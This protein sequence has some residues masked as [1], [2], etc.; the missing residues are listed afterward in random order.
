MRHAQLVTLCFV[1]GSWLGAPALAHACSCAGPLPS[2]ARNA[3]ASDTVFV[4]SVAA[5]QAPDPRL[6]VN[7]AP[8]SPGSRVVVES[9]LS[10]ADGPMRIVFDVRQLYKGPDAGQIVLIADRICDPPFNV[11]QE[12]LVYASER[13][14]RIETSVCSR[15]RLTRE[16][17][18]DI[19]FLDGVA[20]GRQQGIVHGAAHQRIVDAN[21]QP[22]A[23][24]LFESLQVVAVEGGAT[25]CHADR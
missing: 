5:L 23:R 21:D 20:R 24:V 3:L 6:Q 25:V 8:T 18:S 15:I 7:P 10:S 11:G 13:E 14:G 16:A 17:A 12:W 9:V 19:E 22:Q 2:S 1:V 4:G